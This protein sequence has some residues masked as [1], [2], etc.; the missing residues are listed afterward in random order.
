MIEHITNAM[1]A[2]GWQKDRIV[3]AFTKQY[4]TNV[5]PTKQA[6]FWLT[7][8]S[9]GNGWRISHGDFTSAGDNVLSTAS[10][11]LRDGLDVPEIASKI[12]AFLEDVDRRIKS[13]Y[14]MRVPKIRS[15]VRR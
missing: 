4:E 10:L 3:D 13:A 8:N 15:A 14:C 11:D 6:S 1:T 2:H 12:E 9:E 7:R 5:D